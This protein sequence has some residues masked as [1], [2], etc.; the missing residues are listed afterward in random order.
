VRITDEEVSY[1]DE[2]LKEIFSLFSSVGEYEREQVY[3]PGS[4]HYFER[5]NLDAEYELTQERREYAL[6][7]ARAVLTFLH[8]NGYRLER[9]GHIVGLEATRTL[10]AG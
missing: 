3:D 2:D 9:D 1:S 8:R 10:F 6:D 4:R 5:V 7:A